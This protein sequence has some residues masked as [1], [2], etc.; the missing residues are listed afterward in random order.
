MCT[1]LIYSLYKNITRGGTYWYMRYQYYADRILDGFKFEGDI[2]NIVEL[3][4]KLDIEILISESRDPKYGP[5]FNFYGTPWIHLALPKQ[6][7][8]F[9]PKKKYHL[10][11]NSSS[12]T[13]QREWIAYYIVVAY[14]LEHQYISVEFCTHLYVG[15]ASLRN[16]TFHRI[17]CSLLIQHDALFSWTA[18]NAKGYKSYRDWPMELKL[19]AAAHFAVSVELIE[20]RFNISEHSVGLLLSSGDY[21]RVSKYNSKPEQ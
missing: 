15:N 9:N 4:E 20:E 1:D 19:R 16:D 14:L 12:A 17:A 21:I 6:Q 18:K 10:L 8:L 13:E 5:V 2:P 11:I 3:A 7:N